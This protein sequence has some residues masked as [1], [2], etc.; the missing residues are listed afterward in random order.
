MNWTLVPMLNET[1]WRLNSAA[2]PCPVMKIAPTGF[3]SILGPK[4]LLIG[5]RVKLKLL[6]MTAIVVV[7]SARVATWTKT[8]AVTDT[9]PKPRV[10]MPLARSSADVKSSVTVLVFGG[11][12][13]VKLIGVVA[14][15]PCVKSTTHP[16]APLLPFTSSSR[17]VMLSVTPLMPTSWTPPTDAFK[18]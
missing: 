15:G 2:V 3:L 10:T 14:N 12:P 1:F 16:P 4:V 13:K 9:G 5:P 18:A 11:V 7:W 8:S 17:L 6:R